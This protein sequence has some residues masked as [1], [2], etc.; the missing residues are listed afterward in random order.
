L[1]ICERRTY[2][3]RRFSDT[4][5]EVCTTVALEPQKARKAGV[6]IKATIALRADD[7]LCFTGSVA[8]SIDLGGSYS[9]APMMP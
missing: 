9:A 8:V 7:T 2:V 4:D 5:V 6:L 1:A 3:Y